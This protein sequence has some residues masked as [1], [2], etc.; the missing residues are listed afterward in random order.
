VPVWK[1]YTKRAFK[2]AYIFTKVINSPVINC[3][4]GPKILINDE[5]VWNFFQMPYPNIWLYM[6][7]FGWYSVVAKEHNGHP[8]HVS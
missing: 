7:F 3:L 8:I 4:L 2:E 6:E 5:W 1:A